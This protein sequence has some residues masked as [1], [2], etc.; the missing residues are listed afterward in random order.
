MKIVFVGPGAMGCLFAGLLTESLPPS[1]RK[2]ELRRTSRLRSPRLGSGQAGQAGLYDVWLLDKDPVRAKA[3]AGNGVRIDAE[4]GSRIVKVNTTAEPTE[5][6]SADMI[7]LCVKSYDTG[8]TIR[9]ALPLVGSGTI[10][11]SLQNGAGNAEQVAEVVESAQIVCGITAYG[12][13]GLGRGHMRHAGVG[14][15]L[16]APFVSGGRERAAQTAELLTKS[17]IN[18]IAAEDMQSMIWSKLIVN[19]AINPLTAIS[20]VRNGQLVKDHELRA[21]MQKAA[22]E[23][24]AVAKAKDISLMYGNVVKEVEEVCRVTKDNF[25]SMLQDVRR[26][27]RTEIDSITGVIVK[28]AHA[29]GIEAPTNEMLLKRVHKIEHSY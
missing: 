18:T 7:F 21:T 11:V 28:E 19:A 17:G 2:A 27:R 26:H 13:T 9:H 15:T 10:V 20:N 22:L 4:Q 5:I 23:A 29:S 6:G 24:A 16:V 8:A 1:S 25:S 12:A 14:P 3:I